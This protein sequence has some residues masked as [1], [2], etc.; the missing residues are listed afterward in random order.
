MASIMSDNLNAM[1]EKPSFAGDVKNTTPTDFGGKNTPRTKSPKTK[2]P[3]SPKSK[4]PSTGKK[5]FVQSQVGQASTITT[6]KK[7]KPDLEE[8]IKKMF[9]CL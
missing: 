1:E 9:D 7:G 4:S 5:Q 3:R 2:S 8:G 6:S